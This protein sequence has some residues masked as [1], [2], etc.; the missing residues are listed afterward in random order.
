VKN[1]QSGEAGFRKEND[2]IQET[3]AV[4]NGLVTWSVLSLV[5]DNHLCAILCP[6]S[7]PDN[8][9]QGL[10]Q[11]VL[12]QNTATRSDHTYMVNLISSELSFFSELIIPPVPLLSLRLFP[13]EMIYIKQQ[14]SCWAS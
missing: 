1:K 2:V 7:L 6:G 4:K 12:C 3:E 11:T 13:K 8:V 9:A 10:D 5:R 14:P